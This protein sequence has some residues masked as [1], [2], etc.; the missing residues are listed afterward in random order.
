VTT[1]PR[2]KVEGPQLAPAEERRRSQRVVIRI[3]VRLRFTR[4]SKA[5]TIAA[6]AVTVNDH[7]ALLICPCVFPVG[8]RL[9][10]EHENSGRRQAGHVLRVPRITALG[11]EVPVEFDKVVPGFWGIAFP[12]S[13]WQPLR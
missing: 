6:K 8:T 9:E 3:P 2:T 5:E 1:L 7:G 12:P 10:V 4:G 13:D 11:F